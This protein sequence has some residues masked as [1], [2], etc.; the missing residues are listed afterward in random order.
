MAF[1]AIPGLIPSGSSSPAATVN[2]TSEATGMPNGTSSAGGTSSLDNMSDTTQSMPFGQLASIMSMVMALCGAIIGL[3]LSK[4]VAE[5]EKE[6][7][8]EIV[9]IFL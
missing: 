2:G 1:L 5:F 8:Q 9:C 6:G 3:L 7:A 4:R